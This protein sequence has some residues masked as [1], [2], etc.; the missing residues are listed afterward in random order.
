M[1]FLL[2][3]AFCWEASIWLPAVFNFCHSFLSSAIFFECHMLLFHQIAQ[4]VHSFP[5]SC[6]LPPLLPWIILVS[7]SSDSYLSTCSNHTCLRFATVSNIVFVPF[8][9]CRT[10]SL[11]LLF[12][13]II[14]TILLQI[15]ISMA[16]N[17]FLSAWVN[18]SHHGGY[19][20]GNRRC[21]FVCLSVC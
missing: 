9:L 8:T 16:S 18:Y 15:H 5:T 1:T 21:L 14:V 12:I 6:S 7:Y 4:Q 11:L 3:Q 19:V 2:L 17:L 20:P 13:Q 10:S